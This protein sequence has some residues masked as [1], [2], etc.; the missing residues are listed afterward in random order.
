MF[1]FKGPKTHTVFAPVDS[2][3]AHLSVDDLNKL[4]TDKQSAQALVMKHMTPGTLFTAGMRF[5]QVKDS[6]VSGK[7]ITIQKNNGNAKVKV[8][9]G[10]VVTA[11]IPSTNGVIHALDVLL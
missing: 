7:T 2:A 9:E 3:F 10:N 6:M 11:N 4:V 8:N 1:K 5:Y